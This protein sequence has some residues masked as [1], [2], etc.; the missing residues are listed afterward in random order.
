MI[1]GNAFCLC[2]VTVVGQCIGAGNIVDAKKLIRSFLWLS[3]ISIFVICVI[4]L[5][6]FYP[7]AALFNPPASIVPNLYT[8]F[9]INSIASILLWPISFLTP[10]ALR[11]AGDAKFTSIVSML[12]MWLFRIGLGY[13]LGIVFKFGIVG[14]WAAMDCEWGIRGAIFLRRYYGTKWHQHQLIS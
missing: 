14:V 1:P 12:S 4:I 7:L 13:M 11:A 8:I 9:I 6:F 10:S 3:S 5:P 2:V